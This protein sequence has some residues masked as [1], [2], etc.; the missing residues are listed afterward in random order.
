[1]GELVGEEVFGTL[2]TIVWPC[3]CREL[4]T[5]LGGLWL[6]QYSGA[7]IGD[8]GAGM[9]AS[10]AYRMDGW[11]RILSRP[12]SVGGGRIK[13][14]GRVEVLEKIGIILERTSSSSWWVN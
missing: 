11:P 7:R 2:D 1:M 14:R 8:I 12:A 13:E 3:V 4:C 5:F 9:F 6:G 10:G